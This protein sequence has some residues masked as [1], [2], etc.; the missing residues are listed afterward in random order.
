MLNSVAFLTM[1][2]VVAQ[3]GTLALAA[4]RIAMNAMSISFLPGLGFAMAATALVGQSMGAR[5]Y[6]EGRAVASIATRGA[7]IWMGALGVI[8]LF[9]PELILRLFTDDPAVIAYG[10]GALRAFALAQPVWAISMVQ[11]GALR[12]TGD[13]QFPMWVGATSIW[14]AVTL[15]AVLLNLVGGGLTAIWGAFLFTS[16]V[17]AYLLSRRFRKTITA[18]QVMQA[19]PVEPVLA[20][21]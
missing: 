4:H 1:S 20:A 3:L 6:G 21:S 16:P 14:V 18:K 11:G 13:S 9:F 7:M 15:G 12:G 5:Q 2:I 19:E 8:F 17:N 10:T